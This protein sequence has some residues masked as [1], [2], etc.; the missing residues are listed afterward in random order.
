[1]TQPAG[2]D[3]AFDIGIAVGFAA[4][5]FLEAA[6]H[7]DGGFR[8]SSP[9]I[10]SGLAAAIAP[11][12]LAARRVR[13]LV[14]TAGVVVLATAPHLVISFDVILIGGLFVV[15]VALE[16]A[17]RY[18]HRP[19]NRLA[20][21][22]PL[23]PLL[24][25]ALTVP[26]F[27]GQ[28]AVYVVVLAV[29][30]TVGVLFRALVERRQALRRMLDAR[31][32][33]QELSAAGAVAAERASIARE[34][35]DVIAHCVSVMVL[36]AGAARLLIAVD[37]ARSAESIDRIEA[38]GREALVE[39]QR[40]L[41][42]LQAAPGGE[43]FASL[44]RLDRL[45]DQLRAAGLDVSVTVEGDLSAL[46]AGLDRSLYRVVQESLTNALKHGADARADLRLAVA[47]D[48]VEVDVLNPVGG[49]TRV[50]LPGGNGQIGMVERVRAF[51]GEL[52]AGL[53]SGGY[54]VH[55]VVPTAAAER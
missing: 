42:L 28:T 3:L 54:R 17:A 20:T 15:A 21:L 45:T 34:L 53:Y 49:P 31:Q 19:L 1:M 40:V 2:K 4:V 35:H 43:P 9:A 36:Q 23:A 29:G 7:A 39:L 14:S 22:L 47:D 38:T 11:L 50:A 37:P 18:G 6:G 46:P 12:P 25:F 13:P 8:G 51:G 32:A 41:G 26:G 30:W 33:M 5:A 55:A 10:P 48:R 24:L 16:G 27:V 44:A 52:S